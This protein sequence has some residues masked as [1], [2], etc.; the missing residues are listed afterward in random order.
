MFLFMIS[1]TL[2]PFIYTITNRSNYLFNW[3]V[4]VFDKRTDYTT[5]RSIQ[6]YF[7]SGK[8]ERYY[9]KVVG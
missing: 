5:E 3:I 1:N 2:R 6:V 9:L 4:I 8:A 7:Y